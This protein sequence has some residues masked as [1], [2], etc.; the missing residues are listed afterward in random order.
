MFSARLSRLAAS[1]VTRR[2]DGLHCRLLRRHEASRVKLPDLPECSV[3]W[4]ISSSRWTAQTPSLLALQGSLRAS[5]VLVDRL[6][7]N[8]DSSR[9]VGEAEWV[10]QAAALAAAAAG[11]ASSSLQCN[12]CTSPEDLEFEEDMDDDDEDREEE[13]PAR[14]KGRSKTLQ[15]EPAA[16]R[17]R[18]R[19]QGNTSMIASKDGWTRDKDN[20]VMDG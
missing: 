11:V 20:N 16:R 17:L 13:G 18:V 15:N 9:K 4:H 6:P 7:P 12:S 19:S 2:A 1:C 3:P 5:Q 8:P 14:S 10:L